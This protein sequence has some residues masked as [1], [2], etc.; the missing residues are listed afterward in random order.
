MKPVCNMITSAAPVVPIRCRQGFSLI[1]LLVVI[2]IIAILTVLT[3]LSLGGIGASRKLTTAGNLAVDL[4][5]NA[6]QLAS[7]KNTLAM[8]TMVNSGPE[9]GRVFTTLQYDRATD[10]WSRAAEWTVFPEGVAVDLAASA[11]FFDS[12]SYANP[13]NNTLTRAGETISA[14]DYDYAVF[15]P[16]GAPLNSTPGPLVISIVRSPAQSSDANFYKIIVNQ[17]TGIPSVQR[18]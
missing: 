8:L 16:S 10:K 4:I 12:A 2:A 1:E 11:L 9:A 15:L 13:T 7:A 17:S 14:T 3:T 6:S 18:P 5:E